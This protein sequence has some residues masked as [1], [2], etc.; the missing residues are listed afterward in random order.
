MKCYISIILSVF[1]IIISCSDNG[2]FNLGDTANV[3]SILVT[4]LIG[5]NIYSAL[6][7]DRKMTSINKE[8]LRTYSEL[9]NLKTRIQNNESDV[10]YNLV[11]DE[12]NFVNSFAKLNNWSGVISVMELIINRLI[13]LAKSGRN[14]QRDFESVLHITGQILN[15]CKRFDNDTKNEFHGYM[16]LFKQI[17]DYC[18]QSK[19]VYEF[20]E[21]KYKDEISIPS[22]ME[23]VDSLNDKY[24][25]MYI[26]G[27]L[28]DEGV[29]L[30]KSDKGI[31][32]YRKCSM[33]EAEAFYNISDAISAYRSLTDGMG[34]SPIILSTIKRGD[35]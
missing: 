21:E 8:L 9:S 29:F 25:L 35:G 18:P 2:C 5:W 1:A 23:S 28:K 13:V 34:N 22:K 20:Y 16:S 33:E 4:L 7:I 15:E 30:K 24:E 14:M 19:S 27:E 3:L 6:G 17:E 26:V 11:L 10:H 12:L 32:E 31:Y